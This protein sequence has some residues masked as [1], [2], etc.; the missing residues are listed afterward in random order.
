MERLRSIE[1][2]FGEIIRLTEKQEPET[3]TLR[4]SF[5]GNDVPV[6]YL[7]LVEIQQ[8]GV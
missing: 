2:L 8:P 4:T 5:E 1:S 7:Q 3:A 6:L